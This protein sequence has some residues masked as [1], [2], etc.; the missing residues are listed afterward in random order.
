M[1]DSF[2]HLCRSFLSTTIASFAFAFNILR[3][4][5]LLCFLR[6]EDSVRKLEEEKRK[7]EFEVETGKERLSIME[8]EFDSRTA[9]KKYISEQINI[10][11]MEL[12]K[13][14]SDLQDTH[15]RLNEANEDITAKQNRV[16]RLERDLEEKRRECRSYDLERE[17][18]TN[19]VSLC[20]CHENL[21]PTLRTLAST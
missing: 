5:P 3:L 9:E 20:I 6:Y 4:L 2:D 13:L 1:I 12:T 7:L 10:T 16:E 15:R 17:K 18:S 8:R 19:Q 11:H 14:E 21:A